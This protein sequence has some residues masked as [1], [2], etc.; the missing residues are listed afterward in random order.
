MSIVNTLIDTGMRLT[1]ISYIT[2]NKFY[3][4]QEVRKLNVEYSFICKNTVYKF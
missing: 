1:F 2:F 4:Y 3:I